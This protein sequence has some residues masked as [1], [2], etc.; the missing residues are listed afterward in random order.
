MQNNFISILSNIAGGET[1]NITGTG[2]VNSAAVGTNKTISLGSLA[3]SD[4]SGSASNY[5]LSSG[6]FD[7]NLRNITF[8]GTRHYDGTTDANTSNFTS[9]F[10]NLVGGEDLNLTGS[11]S[12]ASKN[13]T[14]GQ[15]ITLGSIALA[16]GTAA[17]SNYNLTSATLDIT[18]RPINLTG[19][20]I[21]D[22]ST[23]ASSSDLTTITNLVGSETIALSG[24][25]VLGN[26]KR[27]GPK[28]KL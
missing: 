13:V 2:T 5:E 12:V 4:N 25:G 27:R 18:K 11:G 14:S 28:K 15:S 19:S 9:T 26:A 7:I 17:S 16:D 23:T 22:S 10:S 8:V 6:T 24:N 3:L 1:L 21:Y 20:R